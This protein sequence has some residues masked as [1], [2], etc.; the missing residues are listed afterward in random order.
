MGIFSKL[1]GGG[2][3]ERVI[4][5]LVEGAVIV[6]VRTPGEF[7]GGHIEGSKNIPLPSL[8]ANIAKIKALKK[9]IVVCCA[10][11]VR[12]AQAKGILEKAGIQVENGG[13]W[14]SLR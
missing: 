6:D 10:S 5:L 12:S 1:F 14:R 11:G 4:Q 7:K 8:Q 13:A 2:R 9:P 3:K